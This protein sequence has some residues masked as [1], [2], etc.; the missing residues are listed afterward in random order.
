MLQFQKKNMI[1]KLGKA[2][3]DQKVL[4]RPDSH[5]GFI[6]SQIPQTAPK[7]KNMIIKFRKAPKDQ[8]VLA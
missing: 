1:I 5:L 4:A 3:K 6:A 7:K 2:P 8:K